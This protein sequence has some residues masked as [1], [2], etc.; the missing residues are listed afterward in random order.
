VDDRDLTHGDPL[1]PQRPSAAGYA[2]GAAPPGAFAPRE[3][4]PWPPAEHEL[5]QW[6]RRAVATLIDGVLLGAVTLALLAALGV[7]VFG[8]GDAGAGEVIAAAIAGTVLFAAIA[9]LY[10][11]VLMARTNGQTLGKMA[12]GCRVVRPGGRR[13]DFLWAAYREVLV[14]GLVV[15]IA[16]SLTGG[17]AYF[18]DVLWPLWDG[19]RRALHDF[20]VGS[21]V[22]R[23]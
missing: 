13:T 21:R 3:V 14:K 1:A 2:P 9:L 8:D 23:S 10:A 19:Q 15:G 16:S 20:V 6:W 5:A 22:V 11:P 4:T 12:A 7:G 18:V 17:I